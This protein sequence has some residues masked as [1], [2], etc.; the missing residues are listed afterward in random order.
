VK[1]QEKLQPQHVYHGYSVT[2]TFTALAV[3]QLAARDLLKL[4]DPAISVLPD[5]PYGDKITIRHLLTHT[6]GIPSPIPVSWIH[7]PAQHASFDRDA[8]FR[9]IF[10][11]H[12]EVKFEQGSR[13]EYSNLGYVFLGLV[14]EKASGLSF[15]EY[16]IQHI[17]QPLDISSTELTFEMHD[18]LLMARGYHRNWSIT[19][20]VLSFMM[21]TQTFMGPAEGAWV[22]FR[23]FYINGAPY[24]GLFG[25]ASGFV[26]YAQALLSSDN[27][28]LPLHWKEMLFT[29]N[30]TFTGKPTGMCLSWFKGILKDQPYFC[31]AGGGGGY[32]CEIR[33]YPQTG[34]G[35]V[36]FLN[37]SGMTDERLLDRVD[38]MFL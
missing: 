36:L 5:F 37:R 29:E 1:E 35:S 3:L 21:D 20:M 14:I 2:K 22:P 26:K 33:L 31:H 19:R 16:I 24:G 15:E 17:I 10:L 8:F 11:K 4:D 30:I 38:A 27:P 7:T 18:T 28:L 25:T 23:D 12:P 13:F 6:A 9:G 32:Y 34:K